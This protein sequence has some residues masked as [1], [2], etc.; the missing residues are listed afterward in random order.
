MI[1]ANGAAK[2]LRRFLDPLH[3]LLFW[4]CLSRFNRPCAVGLH[5]HFEVR[6]NDRAVVLCQVGIDSLPKRFCWLAGILAG[7]QEDFDNE[8]NR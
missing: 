7:I 1:K 5:L 6:V 8:L 4:F 2:R 3:A